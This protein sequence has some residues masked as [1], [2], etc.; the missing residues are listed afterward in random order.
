MRTTVA[1][2]TLAAATV[3]CGGRSESASS[4]SAATST[5]KPVAGPLSTPSVDQPAPKTVDA[6]GFDQL[7]A[8]LPEVSGWT[9][10]K[11]KGEHVTTE[12][13]MSHATAEY[14]KGDASIDVEITDSSFNQLVLSP[15]TI[16]LAGGFSEKSS[17]GFIKS[18]PVNGHPGFEK[19]NH[20]TR[21]AEVTVVVGN[22]FI[23]QAI[24]RNVDSVDPV[25][26]LVK[27][28]DLRKLSSLK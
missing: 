5:S 8:L 15:F 22:R 23:V 11:P 7:I 9:R 24:G 21:H 16:F 6:V 18:A 17:E 2:V 25:R 26:A 27:S 20:D 28:V 10:G 3:A 14:Q 19:W 13:A 1:V 12:A 4:Q